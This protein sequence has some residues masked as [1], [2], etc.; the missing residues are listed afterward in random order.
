MQT[1]GM[2]EVEAFKNNPNIPGIIWTGY[3][4]QA[5]GTAMA[6]I[7]FGAVN[8]GGKLNVT[9]YKSVNDLP[10][11]NDYTLRDG[12]GKGGRTYW[13]S[14]QDVSYEFGFG[15]SYTNFEYSH[16]R[17]NKNRITPN[18]IVTIQVDVKNTGEVDGD[19]IVQIY[20]K[21]PESRAS[22]QR[23]IKRLKGFKRVTI[24][25]GQTKTVSIDIDCSDLWFWDSENNRI[26]FD[27][28]VLQGHQRSG[29]SR[30][31]W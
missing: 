12:S 2:V 19:E 15:L 30:N 13:Y 10:D 31:E 11:F 1:M 7:L 27:R 22:R 21:T 29:G 20:V 28:R 5:Q 9:W 3:N 25:A 24:P 14:N 8:P 23:P 17:I 26:T 6:K 18:D 4:G 16:F